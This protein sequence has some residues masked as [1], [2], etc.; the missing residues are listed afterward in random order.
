[1][2]KDLLALFEY[3]ERERGIQREVV[4]A[5]IREAL[6]AA[7]KKSLRGYA[8]IVA[9]INTR[10]GEIDVAIR[11]RIV[12]TVSNSEEEI[13][14]REA[15][16][17]DEECEEGDFIEMPVT[18]DSL[19]RI[20]AQTA[21]QFMTQR[22]RY[23]ERDVIHQEYRHRL[24][25][26]V[27]GRVRRV[28][29]DGSLIVDLG[30]VEALLPR[31]YYPRTE[32]YRVGERIQALLAEVRDNSLGSAEVILSRTHPKLVVQLFCNEV[33]ELRDGIISIEKIARDPGYRTKMAVRSHDPKV[34]A[35]G[36]CVGIRGMRIKNV[37]R[38]LENEKI[39]VFP[40]TPDLVLLL[41]QA[42]SPMRIRKMHTDEE[43][44]KISIVVDDE[45]YPMAL[46]RKGMNATLTGQLIGYALD[47]QK[48]SSYQ[49]RLS[50]EK[51]A[52]AGESDPALD[53]PLLLE[54]IN[55]LIIDSLR[56]AGYDT[57]RKVLSTPLAQLLEIPEITL[58]MA[59]E[60]FEQLHSRN[61]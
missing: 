51:A 37:I 12:A 18:L 58:E 40:Y 31:S 34:D 26:L 28:S 47:V 23:A 15:Q 39:D 52:L 3:L 55:P 50:I 42:L 22:L 4:A 41:E 13:S 14:L 54:G 19:G 20:A 45:D 36:A 7:T 53:E 49:Q 24:H 11:K 16:A 32:Q 27:S 33:P 17:L 44:R 2:N 48:M 5:A 61:A 9:N 60:I 21:R 46:G 35:V 1:M 43:E 10:S 57:A 8:Q 56:S 59:S 6:I 38:E 30:K 29:Q 25:E